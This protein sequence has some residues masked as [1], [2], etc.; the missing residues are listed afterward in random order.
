VT[1]LVVD[2][3]ALVAVLLGEPEREWFHQT[4]LDNEPLM[5]VA[6]V[7]ETLMVAQGRLGP[8]ALPEVDGFLGDYRI[9]LVPVTAEDLAT[10]R[11]AILDY[12]KGRRAA[13]A[14]LNFGDLFAYALAKRLNAP[15]LFKGHDFALTDVAA[16]PSGGGA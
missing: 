11:Q 16:V 14:A 4:L 2:T 13:P 7:A 1:R 10:I 15:L 8:S 12:G 5:S 3:S 6:S 9:E